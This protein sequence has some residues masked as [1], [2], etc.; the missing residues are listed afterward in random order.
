MTILVDLP[1]LVQLDLNDLFIGDYISR[2]EY[3]SVYACGLDPSLVVKIEPRDTKRFCNQIEWGTWKEAEAGYPE[4]AKW[5]APCKSISAQGSVLL[6]ART[7]P[8]KKLPK[9]LP[10]IFADVKLENFGLYK[11]RIV[12]HDYGNNRIWDKALKRFKMW[13]VVHAA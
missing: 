5:L 10:D 7:K 8:I 13:P 1:H 6:Q 4:I 12:C 11:G 9:E 3:R 2:G